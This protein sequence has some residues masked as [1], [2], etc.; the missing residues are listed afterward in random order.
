[1]TIFTVFPK[2]TIPQLV[3]HQEPEFRD[4]MDTQTETQTKPANGANAPKTRVRLPSPRKVLA[5][6]LQRLVKI[7]RAAESGQQ[8][9][10][11]A[12]LIEILLTQA[13]VGMQLHREHVAGPS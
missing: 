4:D 5:K 6:T 10:S 1:L 2:I 11:Q 7:I 8:E 12:R 3:P 9:L 13:R